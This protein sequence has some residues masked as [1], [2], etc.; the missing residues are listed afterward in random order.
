MGIPL[1]GG[2]RLPPAAMEISFLVSYDRCVENYRTVL[3][4]GPEHTFYYTVEYDVHM[5][6]TLK[7]KC[8]V[9]P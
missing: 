2:R 7:G 4:G 9:E 8:I 6:E 3:T 5:Q 1:E